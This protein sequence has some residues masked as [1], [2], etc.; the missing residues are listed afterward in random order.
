MFF[1]LGIQVKEYRRG[2]W[3]FPLSLRAA[4]FG[5]GLVFAVTPMTSSELEPLPS[6]LGLE[7]CSCDSASDFKFSLAVWR[8]MCWMSCLCCPWRKSVAKSSMEAGLA[9]YF[10]RHPGRM[11]MQ[12]EA[13]GTNAGGQ[14]SRVML[15]MTDCK[16][17]YHC[18]AVC[19]LPPLEQILDGTVKGGGPPQLGGLAIDA[20]KALHSIAGEVD[21][22]E[23]ISIG[24]PPSPVVSKAT[25]IARS[26]VKR[27]V[28]ALSFLCKFLIFAM[29]FWACSATR[30]QADTWWCQNVLWMLE[31]YVCYYAV[32]MY[33]FAR[34]VIC[35]IPYEKL[36]LAVRCI[37]WIW[38]F[39][40][41]WPWAIYVVYATNGMKLECHPGSPRGRI[42]LLCATI[43][44]TADMCVLQ[45]RMYTADEWNIIFGAVVGGASAIE[46]PSLSGG[47]EE[48]LLGGGTA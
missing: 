43:V 19:I 26:A 42:V 30:W 21:V 20:E 16:G 34:V 39:L 32:W 8:S 4:D 6:E 12:C 33:M 44:N 17:S 45:H 13:K 7:M 1:T 2:G 35:G 29:S 38:I 48:P 31:S 10:A 18:T 27:P 22:R 23:G 9:E 3:R 47:P 25:D 37:D 41:F 46:A 28:G 40:G 15:R 5:D 14:E 36:N 24:P 11:T